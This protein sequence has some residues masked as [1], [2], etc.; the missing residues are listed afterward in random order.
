MK[1]KFFSYLL[2]LIIA[3]VLS[4]CVTYVPTDFSDDV[5]SLPSVSVSEQTQEQTQVEKPSTSTTEAVVETKVETK[6]EPKLVSTFKYAH[7]P[8]E[9]AEAMKDII[10]NPLAVYGFS[11]DPRSNRLGSYASYDWTD[12]VF[13]ESAKQDRKAYHDS[14]NT[15]IAIMSSMAADGATEEQIA[16][17]VSAERNRLRLEAYKNDPKQLAEI[18]ASNLKTYGHEDGPTADELY[19]KYGSWS[20]VI[21]KAFSPNLGMDVICGLYD[22]YYPLYVMLGYAY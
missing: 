13:V 19:K 9:N 20:V 7:D 16:R 21:Q 11:P 15:M 17:A 4:S 2:I 1:N 5:Q 3:L 6:T 22:E 8:R 12:P 18:K 10:E 14:L